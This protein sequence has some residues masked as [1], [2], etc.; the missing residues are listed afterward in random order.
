MADYFKVYRRA[1]LKL[2]NNLFVAEAT[3]AQYSLKSV[4]KGL[5]LLKGVEVRR[6]HL[7]FLVAIKSR[8]EENSIHVGRTTVTKS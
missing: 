6:S 5:K 2:D 1:V 4:V 7:D 3:T 8:A